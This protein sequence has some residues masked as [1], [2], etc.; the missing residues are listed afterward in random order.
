MACNKAPLASCVASILQCELSRKRRRVRTKQ[1]RSELKY[2]GF[3]V[4]NHILEACRLAKGVAYDRCQ[5]SAGLSK[6]IYFLFAMQGGW[7]KAG[8]CIDVSKL[9]AYSSNTSLLQSTSA[10][11]TPPEKMRPG[12]LVDLLLLCKEL[13][14]VQLHLEKCILAYSSISF[15]CAKYF[16][17]CDF[18]C[19]AVFVFTMAAIS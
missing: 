16:C 14:R 17:A 15:F 19:W 18:T 11:A 8:D 7:R 12:V 5:A 2:L 3:T 4:T 13:L 1:W 6:Q 10:N 9:M